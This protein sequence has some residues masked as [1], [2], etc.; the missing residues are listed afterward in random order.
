LRFKANADRDHLI[1]THRFRAKNSADY[2]NALRGRGS[3]AV[4]IMDAAT[5]AAYRR[6]ARIITVPIRLLDAGAVHHAG[7]SDGYLPHRGELGRGGLHKVHDRCLAR[8][9]L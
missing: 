1:P 8:D 4:W 3:R 7:G 2:E 5:I 6:S 9:E